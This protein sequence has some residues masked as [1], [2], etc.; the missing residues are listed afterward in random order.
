MAKWQVIGIT[1][2]FCCGLFAAGGNTQPSGGD[3]SYFIVIG[4]FPDSDSAQDRAAVTGGWV[5]RT[6]LYSGLEPGAFLVVRRGPYNSE[7]E[8]EAAREAMTKYGAWSAARVVS[9]GGPSNHLKAIAGD[10]PPEVV[11]AL[12]G[13]LRI[14]LTEHVPDGGLC[15]PDEPYQ[16]ISLSYKSYARQP[17]EDGLPGETRNVPWERPLDIG[18]F[19]RVVRS[20]ELSRLRVCRE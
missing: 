5:L 11:A 9:G 20:G 6:D 10:V 1:T 19:T 13:E 14:G 16:S 7:Q 17:V 8:A 2:L 4:S 15:A 3:A 12:L 18:H